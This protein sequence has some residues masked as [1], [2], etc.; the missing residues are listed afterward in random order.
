MV[1]DQ[2]RIVAKFHAGLTA[3]EKRELRK[4]CGAAIRDTQGKLR[5]FASLQQC[6]GMDGALSELD[7]EISV[8]MKLTKLINAMAT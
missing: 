6:S 4:I 1:G 7:S 8:M 2:A 5:M 3:T